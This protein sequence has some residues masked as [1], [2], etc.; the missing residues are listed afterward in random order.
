MDRSRLVLLERHG[1]IREKSFHSTCD[2]YAYVVEPEK[3]ETK[4]KRGYVSLQHPPTNDNTGR[5]STNQHVPMLHGMGHVRGLNQV[6]NDNGGLAIDG[7]QGIF[8][9]ILI[10]KGTVPTSIAKH[11]ELL[12]GNI[13]SQNSL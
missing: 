8:F 11:L 4:N 6:L 3:E 2:K 12:I 7:R 5:N 13:R 10:G 9:A 1:N